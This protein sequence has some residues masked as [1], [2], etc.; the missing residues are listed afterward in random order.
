[1]NTPEPVENK[2]KS[3]SDRDADLALL[4]DAARAAGTLALT[5]FGKQPRTRTKND[6]T[7]VSE[8]DIAVDEALKEQLLAARPGYGWLSEETDDE[9][10]RLEKDRVWIID[11]IDGTRAFLKEKP[12]WTVSAALVENGQP[13]LGVVYNPAREEIYHAVR[14]EGAHLNGK[15]I[16]VNDPVA[17]EQSRLV[18]SSGLFRHDIWDR[19]MPVVQTHWVNSIAYR[20]ALVA[21]GQFD[22]TVSLSKKHDWDLAAADLL[23]QEAGGKATTHTGDSFRYNQPKPL[24]RSVLAAGPSLHA[25]LLDRT[26]HAR[27]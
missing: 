7:E 1:M 27:I 8:A 22:G 23:V 12:E 2:T 19:P 6:G 26:L 25:E 3:S 14:R 21:S 13:V 18:A 20:M 17:L 4:K 10:S 11:P 24:Q 5:F 9:A 16:Q 15:P